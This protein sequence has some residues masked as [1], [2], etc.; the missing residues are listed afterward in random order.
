MK[1][2]KK[3]KTQ[4]KENSEKG[5]FFPSRYGNGFKTICDV[6]IHPDDKANY[7]LNRDV[8]H[9]GSGVPKVTTLALGKGLKKSNPCLYE[10]AIALEQVHVD[11]AKSNCKSFK[12]C[13]D[14]EVANNLFSSYNSKE[15]YDH[16]KKTHSGGLAS[17]CIKDEQQAYTKSVEIG[18]KLLLESKCASEKSNLEKNIAKWKKNAVAP[19]NC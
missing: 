18:E 17:D 1:R 7:L 4:I 12:K 13:L 5:A 2:S 8:R 16:C 14:D 3:K 11:N 15:E 6:D 19:P 9:V 10:A